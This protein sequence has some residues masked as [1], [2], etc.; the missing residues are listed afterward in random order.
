MATLIHSS[1][2][3]I[4]DAVMALKLIHTEVQVDER[5]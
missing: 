1:I 3:D 2:I 4:V 5:K